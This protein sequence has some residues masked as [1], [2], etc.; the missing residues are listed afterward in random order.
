MGKAKIEA[1][2]LERIQRKTKRDALG[3]SLRAARLLEIPVVPGAMFQCHMFLV[4]LGHD[5]SIN[6][7]EFDDLVEYCYRSLSAGMVVIG[8]K[9]LKSRIPASSEAD[10]TRACRIATS[11]GIL[12]LDACVAVQ[13]FTCDDRTSSYLKLSIPVVSG[14]V[15]V[16]QVQ[17][18]FIEIAPLTANVPGAKLLR[19]VILDE[20]KD[21]IDAI[22]GLNDLVTSVCHALKIQAEPLCVIELEYCLHP[23]L[24]FS[25]AIDAW[26]NHL[27][28]LL[29]FID[30]ES[31]RQT[32]PR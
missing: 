15:K 5:L 19:K 32:T 31:K 17:S 9:G 12:G 11:L 14:S 4:L 23:F 20:N 28:P 13:E 25:W 27:V 16:N 6:R 8:S 7:N 24:V 21:L 2:R 1:K 30:R 10:V 18:R 26:T 3:D 29:K 22:Y